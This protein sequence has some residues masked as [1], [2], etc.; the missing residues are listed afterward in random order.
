MK[1]QLLLGFAMLWLGSTMAHAAG[2]V[3]DAYAKF[4]K[5]NY[6]PVFGSLLSYRT[7]TEGTLRV[8]FMLAVSGCHLGKSERALGGYLLSVI[9]TWYSPLSA[10][11][12]A[13]VRAQALGCPQTV[14]EQVAMAGLDG[15]YDR[16]NQPLAAG[17]SK[18]GAGALPPAKIASPPG[19][20]PLID[21]LA[22]LQADYSNVITASAYACAE[23]CVA[24][25]QCVAITYIKSQ[26][27]CWLKSTVPATSRSKD[28]V[29]AAKSQ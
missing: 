19:M 22:Y 27:R 2:V 10:S 13:A 23:R 4:M 12:L 25:S 17:H 21:G 9:P 20:G 29:S 5:G 26:K 14:S 28:M 8:D 24:A 3:D 6:R 1:K 7:D 18:S 11:N 15:K 16:G